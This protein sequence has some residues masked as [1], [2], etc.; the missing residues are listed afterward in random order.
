M[1]PIITAQRRKRSKTEYQLSLTALKMLVS[2]YDTIANDS[3]IS[4]KFLLLRTC[5]ALFMT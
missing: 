3:A 4:L 2:Y 1:V 5:K